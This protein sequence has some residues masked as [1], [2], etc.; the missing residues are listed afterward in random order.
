MENNQNETIHT[1]ES[2]TALLMRSDKAVD[3]AII[4][5]YDDL[6]YVY[7]RYRSETHFDYYIEQRIK[8]FAWF[9]RGQD[10][11]GNVRWEPKSLA[12]PIA[13]RQL[14]KFIPYAN[15]GKR[16]IDAARDLAIKF[17]DHIVNIANGQFEKDGEM[18][19]S[20]T[21]PEH[22]SLGRTSQRRYGDS[23]SYDMYLKSINKELPESMFP[24]NYEIENKGIEAV[25]EIQKGWR[26]FGKYP[27]LSNVD[28]RH[29]IER[30][31][32]W[33][34]THIYLD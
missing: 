14:K 6:P 31:D 32:F 28:P 22:I 10:E 3:R 25:L 8:N 29:L 23:Y 27:E 15:K 17:V 1:V 30:Y 5:L 20:I 19:D 18:L 4:R 33:K 11:K 7:V 12:H 21:L 24:T 13:D 2:I 16:C 26:H 34:T 9:I